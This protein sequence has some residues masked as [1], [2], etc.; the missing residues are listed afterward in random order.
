M[1]KLGVRHRL[2]PEFLAQEITE[3]ARLFFFQFRGIDVRKRSFE[4]GKLFTGQLAIDPCSPLFL[5]RFHKHP[6]TNS[7]VSC[8]HKTI[9]TSPCRSSSRAIRRSRGT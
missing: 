3:L 2:Q 8:A 6:S 7:G 1:E 5:K 4:L 9:G